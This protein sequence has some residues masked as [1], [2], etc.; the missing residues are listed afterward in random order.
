MVCSA[1]PSHVG[2]DAPRSRFFRGRISL[3]KSL[4]SIRNLLR[5]NSGRTGCY[6]EGKELCGRPRGSLM[7]FKPGPAATP[8]SQTSQDARDNGARPS[9]PPHPPS[10][11]LTCPIVSTYTSLVLYR[12]NLWVSWAG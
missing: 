4:Q 12:Q 8:A 3:R 9:L 2:G 10:N 5:L 11:S 6:S 7:A 1:L